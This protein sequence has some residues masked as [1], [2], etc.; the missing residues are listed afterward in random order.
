MFSDVFVHLLQKN[1]ISAY[2][3]SKDLNI[4]QALISQWKSNK[5]VPSYDNILKLSN[6]FNVSADYLLERTNIQENP[7]LPSKQGVNK[8]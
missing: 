8:E 4:S 2:A 3:L 7:N 6:Y 1:N 5:Q